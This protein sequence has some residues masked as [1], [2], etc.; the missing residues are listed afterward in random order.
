MHDRHKQFPIDSDHK[1]VI[2]DFG[3]G[4][5]RLCYLMIHHL[6]KQ[7]HLWP[8]QEECPFQFVMTDCSQKIINWWKRNEYLKPYMDQG[9]LDVCLYDVETMGNV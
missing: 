3:A 4:H 5:G 6:L 2:L 8:D 9:Y 7:R 1:L